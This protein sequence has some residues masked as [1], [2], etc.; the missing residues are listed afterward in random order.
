MPIASVPAASGA[1]SA[2]PPVRVAIVAPSMAILGG[3]AVQADRLLAA[4]AGDPDVRAWL[5]PVNPV[6]IRPLRALTRIRFAR[7]LVV[8][9]TYW[10]LLARELRRADVVHVF[11]ASYFSFLLAPLPAVLVAR[12]LGRPVVMNYRSGEA[13][14]HLAR[15]AVART[16]LRGVDRNVVP[17]KF[18]QEVFARFG[19]AAEVVPNIVDLERF[20]FRA[21][22]SP[23][24]RLLS[25]RNFERLYNVSCTLDAFARVQ[26]RFPEAT[27]TLVGSGSEEG[28]LR[29]QAARLGLHG[30][31]FA[32]RVAPDQIWR[33]YA[34]ADIYVQTPD[35]DNMPS[36]VLEAFAS[37]CAVV[38]TDAGGVPAILTHGVHGLLAPRG[39]HEAVAEHVVQLIDRPQ[40]AESLTRRARESCERY[41]WTEV[42]SEWLAIYRQL[43]GSARR[44]PRVE[45]AAPVSA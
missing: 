34:D 37:G 25:T 40:L 22:P 16:V 3:Q 42:R 31:T 11:S 7:T 23:G 21:R 26:A 19:I 17:S 5:V 4:W 9:A 18:L 27:L 33:Y 41:R 6:P 45:P 29:R 43:M 20:A 2:P 24:P 28:A 1:A 35:I 32:G 14:D 39:D 13:P 12:L 44:S 15:S 36:S 30:V 38:S 10:P 8:Q